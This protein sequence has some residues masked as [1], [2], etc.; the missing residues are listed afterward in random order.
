M[1]QRQ[2]PVDEKSQDT[3]CKEVSAYRA[4]SKSFVGRE[5][6]DMAQTA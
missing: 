1:R 4:P 6:I 3:D 2:A 5:D